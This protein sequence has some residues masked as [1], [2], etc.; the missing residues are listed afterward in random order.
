MRISTILF[1]SICLFSF[2]AQAMK[3]L[4]S[5]CERKLT[6]DSDHVL[7]LG[8]EQIAIQGPLG[9]YWA[10]G[11][12]EHVGWIV[13]DDFVKKNISPLPSH[14][15][16]WLLEG[17]HVFILDDDGKVKVSG[18]FQ[19]RIENEEVEF[20]GEV[21]SIQPNN[22]YLFRDKDF[23]ESV[24]DSKELRKMFMTNQHVVVVQT[25]PEDNLVQLT[26]ELRPWY[27]R[28]SQNLTR[29][30]RFVR[31]GRR[32]AVELMHFHTARPGVILV[33]A[34]SGKS[35]EM[36]WETGKF[37]PGPTFYRHR[38]KI[39]TSEGVIGLSDGEILMLLDENELVKFEATVGSPELPLS[40]TD[41]EMMAALAEKL[42]TAK[43]AFVVEFRLR[44]L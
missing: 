17:D 18:Y 25:L 16:R 13:A 3:D 19:Q 7:N 12:E 15:Q 24:I 5:R 20:G 28:Y 33:E 10:Q 6:I 11:M 27:E 32:R 14:Y 21:Q 44:D 36:D 31:V 39:A 2:R 4:M 1:V 40:S 26:E 43:S 42:R 9:H 8:P 41:Q 35:Q 37:R 30:D 23:M 34:S 38:Y 22:P 29:T